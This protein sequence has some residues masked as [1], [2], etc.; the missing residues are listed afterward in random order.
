[1][2]QKEI[3]NML[4]IL[5]SV[6]LLVLVFFFITSFVVEKKQ[7]DPLIL[8]P[9]IQYDEILVNSILNRSPE[10]YYVLVAKNMDN[11]NLY[12]AYIQIAKTKENALKVYTVNLENAFNISFLKETPNLSVTNINEIAFSEDTLILV[13]KGKIINSFEGREDILKQLEVMVK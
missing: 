12:N 4:I 5:G 7:K 9:A 6:I 10:K 1:M 11:T 8:Q 2:E 13:E 3:K